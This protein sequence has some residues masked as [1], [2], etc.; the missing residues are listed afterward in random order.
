MGTRSEQRQR[1]PWPELTRLARQRFGI[2]RLR[3]GQRE[4]IDRVLAGRDTLGVLPTGGGKSLCFQLPALVLTRATVVVS[5]LIAL[6]QDQQ[7]KLAT[8]QVPAAKLD[9]TLTA[10]E[11]HATVERIGEGAPEIVYVTPERLER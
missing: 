5:P 8:A 1:D 4:I 3:P 9:S 11:E 6:M 7:E 10:S 2:A